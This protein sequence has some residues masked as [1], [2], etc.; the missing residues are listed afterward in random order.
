VVQDAA[1]EGGNFLL[2]SFKR[3]LVA[4]S[5]LAPSRM[6]SNHLRVAVVGNSGSGKS[7]LVQRVGAECSLPVR[8]LDQIFWTS[9]WKLAEERE[10]ELVHERWL[11]EKRW[12]I[13]GVGTWKSLTRRC[14]VADLIVFVDT[15]RELCHARA[16][17]RMDEDKKCPNPY[18]AAGCR[19][20]DVEKRQE[21]VI[22]FFD[23]TLRPQL[24]NLL[25]AHSCSK[26]TL[27]LDGRQP[28]LELAAR[29]RAEIDSFSDETASH[30]STP[31]ARERRRGR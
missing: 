19:Y 4:T 17:L 26:A 23:R 2:R 24:V 5:S 28:V 15:P 11:A 7:T 29:F 13:D 14:D 9:A 31:P 22:D 12:I 1:G 30:P 25:T 16:R 6:N 10:F 21:Q 20:A 3:P 18:I 8:H 27:V